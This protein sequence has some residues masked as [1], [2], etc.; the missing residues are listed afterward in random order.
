MDLDF[1]RAAPPTWDADVEE[2]YARFLRQGG[3]PEIWQRA[4]PDLGPAPA[5]VEAPDPKRPALTPADSATLKWAAAAWDY[6]QAKATA[7]LRK[8]AR[9]RQGE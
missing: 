5:S 9:G 2:T 4:N 3:T 7:R 6:G 1:E 8:S